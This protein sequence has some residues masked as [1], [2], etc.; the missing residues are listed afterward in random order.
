MSRFLLPVI[1]IALLPVAYLLGLV[2]ASK[3]TALEWEQPV[4]VI[5]TNTPVAV[6]AV[7]PHGVREFTAV[8]L[9]GGRQF[10]VFSK[11]EGAIRWSLFRKA[12]N[13]RSY[14]FEAGS[15]VAPGLA[16][17]KA[18]LVVEAVANDL[19]AKR[20][21]LALPVEVNTKPPAL[22]V[23]DTQIVMTQGGA[24][25]VAFFVSGYWTEAG[26]RIGSYQFRSFPNPGAKD[27]SRRIC[28]FAVPYDLPAGQKP[29]V[30]AR[31]PAG[32]E[33]TA[34]VK[35][36][37][38]RK[39]FR[40]RDLDLPQSFI[41]KVLQELDR[42]GTGDTVERFRRVNSEMRKAN[43]QT[44][45]DLRLKTEDHPLWTETFRQL[46][47][48]AVQAQFCDYRKYKYQGKVI[49]EQVH[50][51]FDLASTRHADVVAAN[52]GRV[53]YAAPLGIY[54]NAVV[55]DHGLAVQSLYAHLSEIKVKVGD[56]VKRGQLLGQSGS[57]GL[58]GG[59]HLHF[60]M[61]VD[62]VAVNPLEWW[63]PAWIE[64]RLTSRYR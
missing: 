32:V 54:G 48:T 19:W 20:T 28:I 36:D 57:T 11:S 8:L 17:G 25:A 56:A 43:N 6:R 49:D 24:G 50:L 4:K 2:L 27:P 62:G 3:N 13:P 44:L 59:D 14:Q 63:D 45:Y 9:Q 53:I 15:T 1:L 37:L 21:R 23:D 47:N 35:H 58:A 61:Q 26:V 52:D 39:R 38:D 60:S 42:G 10:P 34:P 51:G 46:A 16:D 31:N 64:K 40:T 55:V 30:F 41:D 29:V 22:Q 7:N 12:E 18:E 5:G 33:V